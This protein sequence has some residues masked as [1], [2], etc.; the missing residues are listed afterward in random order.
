MG[1]ADSGWDVPEC[2]SLGSG[3]IRFTKDYLTQTL[4]LRPT[5]AGGGG[6]SAAFATVRIDSLGIGN[7]CYK[8][9]SGY[10]VAVYARYLDAEG[11][12]RLTPCLI[13]DAA[14]DTLCAA[15]PT[16]EADL[17]NVSDHLFQGMR[18]CMFAEQAP[19]EDQLRK[20]EGVPLLDFTGAAPITDRETLFTT[21]AEAVNLRVLEGS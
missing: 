5:D 21:V 3:G 9:H 8:L 17:A 15:T 18:F 20:M 1:A 4:A 16:G 12:S 14:S 11:V 2:A 13:S 7:R 10:C 6:S 19:M